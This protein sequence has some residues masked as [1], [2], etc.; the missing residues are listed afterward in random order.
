MNVSIADSSI[1][2]TRPRKSKTDFSFGSLKFAAIIVQYDT[3][4]IRG[5]FVARKIRNSL[6]LYNSIHVFIFTYEEN[7]SGELVKGVICYNRRRWKSGICAVVFFSRATGSEL[8]FW[9]VYCHALVHWRYRRCRTLG[10]ELY[11]LFMFL[12]VAND[13]IKDDRKGERYCETIFM[14]AYICDSLFLLRTL[15]HLAEI[16]GIID[17]M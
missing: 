8:H 7:Q 2:S 10:R 13:P 3:L 16:K 1:S 4:H 6:L 11:S 9:N 5:L 14:W 15:A 17:C 12:H